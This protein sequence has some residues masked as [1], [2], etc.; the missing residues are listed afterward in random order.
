S[1]SSVLSESRPRDRDRHVDH[2]ADVAGGNLFA[3]HRLFLLAGHQP[4]IDE[5]QGAAY[6]MDIGGGQLLAAGLV[7][8]LAAYLG[9]VLGA[10]I[11]GD[12]GDDVARLA[13][14]AELA[15]RRHV[16]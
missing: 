8:A 13:I 7:A 3:G 16:A 9:G 10:D 6:L 14:G 5:L 4:G 2:I 1:W 11:G 12:V 15:E